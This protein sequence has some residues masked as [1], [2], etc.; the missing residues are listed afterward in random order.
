MAPPRQSQLLQPFS[1]LVHLELHMPSLPTIDISADILERARAGDC[2]AHE[3]IYLLFSKPVYTL[4]RRLVIRPAVAEDLLQDVFVEIL[5]NVQNYAGAGSF[6]GWVKSIAVSKALMY[7]R[8][9]WH[10]SV[11]WLGTDGVT[12]MHEEAASIA[13]DSLDTSLERALEALPAVGRAIV[14]LHDVEGYTHAEIA[15]LFR[16]TPSFS[17]S[18]LARA[19]EHL[20]ECLESQSGG[21]ACMPISR[22]C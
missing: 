13:V 4:I 3:C 1:V 17:K 10:R 7:L 9:P 20:R 11:A 14:W 6:S 15:R 19:H 2:H 12:L 22:N 5:R 21:L 16:R 8:S 18:Q